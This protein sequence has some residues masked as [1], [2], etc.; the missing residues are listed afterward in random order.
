MDSWNPD[1]RTTVIIVLAEIAVFAVLKLLG[2]NPEI[3]FIVI[4]FIYMIWFIGAEGGIFQRMLPPQKDSDGNP[5]VRTKIEAQGGD[6]YPRFFRRLLI[7]L[8]LILIPF[9]W[10]SIF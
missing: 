3:I 5:V 1:I 9:I 8:P 4:A 2:I 7:G 10:N 6:D